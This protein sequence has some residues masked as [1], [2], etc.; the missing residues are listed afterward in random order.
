MTFYF[1]I[2]K[3][4]PFLTR[5]F[6]KNKFCA[7]FPLYFL[8]VFLVSAN[9]VSEYE[10]SLISSHTGASTVPYFQVTGHNLSED[11]LSRWIAL[12]LL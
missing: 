6:Q 12:R 10:Q 3:N 1:E 11:N 9:L 2:I 7:S 5:K 8:R 4:I